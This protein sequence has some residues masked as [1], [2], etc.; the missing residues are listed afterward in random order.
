MSPRTARALLRI[1]RA[2]AVAPP[3]A[4]AWHAGRISWCQAQALVALVL[5]PGSEPFHSFWIERAAHVT[6][7]RLE[8]DVDRA[9]A[10]GVFDPSRLP[11]VP[12]L[13]DLANLE[14][15]EG[16]QIGAGPMGREETHTW[17]ANVPADV[18]RLFRACLHTV[19]RHLNASP[20]VALEAMFLHCIRHVAAATRPPPARRAAR[21][22]ARRLALHG[23]GRA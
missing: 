11:D 15:P 1:E 3:L 7:R 18:A 10:R 22:R 5:A 19:Q 21:V 20:G 9:L 6:L 23:A 14:L 4:E 2:C 8:D 12:D 17:V 13:A 16:V